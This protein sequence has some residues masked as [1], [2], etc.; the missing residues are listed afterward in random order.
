MQAVS[1]MRSRFSAIRGLADSGDL[2][3]E[4]AKSY[5]AVMILVL[6]GSLGFYSFTTSFRMAHGEGPHIGALNTLSGATCV[7]LAGLLMFFVRRE[8]RDFRTIQ[9]VNALAFAA[10]FTNVCI[11][12]FLFSDAF[13]L[14]YLCIFILGIAVGGVSFAVV[15]PGIVAAVV[16]GFII[17]AHSAPDI[18]VEYTITFVACV[19]AG[20][21]VAGMLRAI[22]HGEIRA[23]LAAEALGRAARLEADRDAL[24]GLGNRR[25]F[26]R[27]LESWTGS[28]K[29]RHLTLF[30]IDVDGFKAVNDFYGHPAGDAALVEVAQ[31]LNATFQ[32]MDATIVRLGGDEFAVA[33]ELGQDGPERDV[34]GARVI[35]VM[36][37]PID[38]A[39]RKAK[40]SASVGIVEHPQFGK[41][42]VAAFECAD[43]ALIEAKRSGKDC[44][45]MF[46]DETMKGMSRSVDVEHALQNSDLAAEM[47]LMFQP[48]LDVELGQVIGFEALARWNSGLLGVVAPN[49]FI[50]CAER[51]GLIRRLTPMLLKKALAEA[52][53]WPEG[54]RLSFNLSSADII[55]EE[56]VTQVIQ[57]VK[58]SGI[59]PE[60]LTLEITETAIVEEFHRAVIS[61]YRL[62]AMGIR[63]SMD[64]FGSGQSSFGRLDELPLDEVKL[65]RHFVS[66]VGHSFKTQK[67]VES[68]LKLCRT[69]GMNCVI[70]GVE[71]AQQ[72]DVLR[73]VG[74]TVFQGYHSGRPMMADAV[75]AFA[76]R[77]LSRF[78][79]V[80]DKSAASA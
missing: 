28:D 50:P 16:A 20:L 8:S 46:S 48:Q 17:L 32:D 36:R 62:S 1:S 38:L 58:D 2:G 65:D 74:G 7:L 61:I 49:E 26:M 57:T 13:R 79:G 37:K 77:R 21:T 35:D 5:R 80:T 29:S 66:Q 24:T 42:P 39:G 23:R 52:K 59:L 45:V 15:V 33:A 11:E 31:R 76:G 14:I 63:I 25:A 44:F 55:S 56:G 53:T 54:L 72:L 34:V 22:V 64:D 4:L 71:T 19:F 41:S 9:W 51:L 10:I 70:E 40:M 68:V 73:S 47:S 67:I 75:I 27:H 30:S 3:L 69:L 6:C 60:R 43:F 12:L 78:D 18:F